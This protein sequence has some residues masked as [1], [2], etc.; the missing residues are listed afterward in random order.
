MF[1]F[2]Y[3]FLFFFILINLFGRD[4]KQS[5]TKQAIFEETKF[6][7]GEENRITPM[8][9]NQSMS[10]K[11]QMSLQQLLPVYKTKGLKTI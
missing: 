2:K 11:L 7:L 8:E 1:A 3:F 5:L 10:Q 9:S 6:L 4:L